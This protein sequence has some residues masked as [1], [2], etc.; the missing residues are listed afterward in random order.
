LGN[1][2]DECKDND[3]HESRLKKMIPVD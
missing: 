2:D 3:D 1:E